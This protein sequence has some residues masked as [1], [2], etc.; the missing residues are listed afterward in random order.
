MDNKNSG[1]II[2]HQQIYDDLCRDILGGVYKPGQNLP[3][4]KELANHFKASRPTIA[5]AMRELQH[6]GLIVRRQG[7]GT[8]VRQSSTVQRNSIGLLVHWQIRPENYRPDNSSTIFGIMIPEILRVASRFN[9][10]LLLNDIPEDI[11]D[12]IER[13]RNICKKLIDANVGGVFFTP[14]ELED[15]ADSTNEKRLKV[16]LKEAK[17]QGQ[18]NKS[19]E[20][21]FAYV[22]KHAPELD[23]PAIKQQLTRVRFFQHTDNFEKCAFSRP[24]R[25]DDNMRT[26]TINIKLID[27]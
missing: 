13:A 12:P 26:V 24:I 22:K 27:T 17:G 11:V 5:K 15:G 1:K 16:V 23:I 20:Q 21:Y 6:K 10:S 19:G 8:F 25:A 2:K 18:G 7:H 14:L 9:Y 4:E 3:T